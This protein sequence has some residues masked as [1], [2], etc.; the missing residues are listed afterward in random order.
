MTQKVDP[1]I[2]IEWIYHDE[3]TP[4]IRSKSIFQATGVLNGHL[5]GV[6]GPIRI[7]RNISWLVK[8]RK[9]KFLVISSVNSI[10]LTVFALILH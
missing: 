3:I 4:K 1:M 9:R 2:Q 10:F 8:V 7:A 5:Y 6:L